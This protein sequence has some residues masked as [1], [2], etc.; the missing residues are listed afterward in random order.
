[1]LIPNPIRRSAGQTIVNKGD[2]VATILGRFRRPAS[3][4][5]QLTAANLGHPLTMAG[6]PPGVQPRVVTKEGMRLN[7]PRQWLSLEAEAV[8]RKQGH[9]V[10]QAGLLGDAIEDAVKALAP[11]V[12]TPNVTEAQYNDAMATL[13]GW[14]RRDSPDQIPT[15]ELLKPYMPTFMQ[16]RQNVLT[17]LPVGTSGKV[18]WG[19]IPIFGLSNWWTQAKFPLDKVNWPVVNG[20][21][22]GKVPPGKFPQNEMGSS[23]AGVDF[24]AEG[25]AQKNLSPAF[26]VMLT[27]PRWDLLPLQQIDPTTYKG[28]DPTAW[29]V[30]EINKLVGY[31]ADDGMQEAQALPAVPDFMGC[32]FGKVGLGGKCYGVVPP[33]IDGKCPSEAISYGGVCVVSPCPA[34]SMATVTSGGIICEQ[35]GPVGPG[36]TPSNQGGGGQQQG[37]GTE[38]G[39]GLGCP[40]G[41]V[42]LGTTSCNCKP[43]GDRFVYEAIGN[44]CV[45]CGPNSSWNSNTQGC[46]CDPGHVPNPDSKASGAGCVA[47]AGTSTAP[48][49]QQQ[50]PVTTTK[51]ITQDSPSTFAKVMGVGGLLVGGLAVAYNFFGTKK[52]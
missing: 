30:K 46:Q 36:G 35:P 16:Y 4:Y 5:T 11:Y 40:L 37:G 28:G 52:R 51:I 8:F 47:V 13:A 31:Q 6:L 27:Q 7:I 23:W 41:A 50:P 1:M 24:S 2:T 44:V 14:F 39:P 43:L 18:P 17:K 22:V 34:G 25:V 19:A 21:L 15:V 10:G 45:D 38:I 32:G 49:G 26:F 9:L 3:D 12:P 20:V 33:G 42:P 29:L 48:P